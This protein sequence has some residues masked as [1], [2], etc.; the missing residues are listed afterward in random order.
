VF[1]NTDLSTPLRPPRPPVQ[2]PVI[3][4][5]QTP[6]K[7][8]SLSGSLSNA[9][10]ALVSK[11]PQTENSRSA[12]TPCR[13]ALAACRLTLPAPR[14]LPVFQSFSVSEH[15]PEHPSVLSVPSC[16]TPSHCTRPNPIEIEIA[17]GIAIERASGACSQETVERKQLLPPSPRLWRTGSAPTSA[18]C[19][20]PLPLSV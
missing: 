2:P 4:P 6:S 1:R 19:A 13:S 17:I 8:K 7:S 16:S 18:L 14:T 11:R 10:L 3:A 5:N 9:P 20:S 12:L 15:R